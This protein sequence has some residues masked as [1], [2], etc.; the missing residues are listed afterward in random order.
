[1]TLEFRVI[2]DV[3]ST[4][5]GEK[6]NVKFR[7]ESGPFL[8][9]YWQV[10]GAESLGNARHLLRLQ[11]LSEIEER[12]GIE[13]LVA[14]WEIDYR[15]AERKLRSSKGILIKPELLNEGSTDSVNGTSQ[16]HAKKRAA[17]PVSG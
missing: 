7:V 14:H 6:I 16:G 9:R 15:A 8:R 1:M 13:I 11:L 4:G 17:S 2:E 10:N 3:E 5:D 12:F